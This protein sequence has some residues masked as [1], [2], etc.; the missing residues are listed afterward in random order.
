MRLLL[1]LGYSV[2][3]RCGTWSGWHRGIPSAV[4]AVLAAHSW[5]GVG[6]KS[7]WPVTG[8]WAP[9]AIA[10]RIM[11]I[12]LLKYLEVLIRLHV[13]R[14]ILLT[15]CFSLKQF[16]L[17]EKRPKEKLNTAAGHVIFFSNRHG[18]FIGILM[19]YIPIKTLSPPPA[20]ST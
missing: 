12:F 17:I 1:P 20:P 19:K 6:M 4:A 11:M 10:E 2:P 13:W 5:H 15:T 8:S 16:M 7:G 18:T 14:K 9:K 3:V